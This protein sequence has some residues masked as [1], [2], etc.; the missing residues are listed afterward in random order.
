LEKRGIQVIRQFTSAPAN[1]KLDR[2]RM[3]QI[4]G[5]L[6]RNV[7]ESFDSQ[8]DSQQPRRLEISVENLENQWVR[9]TCKDTGAGFPP[10]RAES[11]FERGL[12]TKETGSGIGLA[13]CRSTLDAHG[14]LIRMESEGPG[15]GA[16]VIIDLPAGES[17][18]Q[19]A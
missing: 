16:I 18:K 15:K 1:V 10:D 5:T 2:T 8:A 17:E 11:F 4:L 19:C 13:N 9:I 14:G 12:T 7:C 6:I 3:V